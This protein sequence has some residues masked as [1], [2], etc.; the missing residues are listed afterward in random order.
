MGQ[1]LLIPDPRPLDE[2]LG[3]KFFR[4]APKRTGVYLMR[5]AADRVLYVGKARNL[6]QRLRNYRIANPDR[7]P[8]RHLRMVR[9][10]ARIEFQFCPG[11]TAALKRESKLL[12]S[13]RPKFNRAGVWP[14]KTR[15]LAWR[16]SGQKLELAVTDVP[17]ASW[18]R[19]GPLGSSAGHL[20]GTLL[21]LLWLAMNPARSFAELPTGWARGNFP[22]GAAIDCSPLAAEISGLLDTFFWESSDTLAFWLGSRFTTRIH[23]FERGVI[24]GELEAL[25]EFSTKRVQSENSGRQLALL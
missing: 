23:P 6:Q 25:N 16:L 24:D 1:L 14:G 22:E 2:R 17:E 12:R 21:R 9:E 10:V 11:E 5:D 8:R 4:K 3:R 19:F 7:M 18:R 20:R 15:F 13:L